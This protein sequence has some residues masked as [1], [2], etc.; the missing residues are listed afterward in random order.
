MLKSI[1]A[2][3]GLMSFALLA[4]SFAAD[5]VTLA[6]PGSVTASDAWIRWLPGELPA[7]AYVTLRNDSA[8]DT[9]LV[10]VSSPDY[11]T[12]MFHASRI[13]N[14][15]Q[16]ML[17]L[18]RVAIASHA[19]VSFTPQAMHVMLMLPTRSIIPGEEVTLIFR[20]SDGARLP[21]RF[22]VRRPDGT[23]MQA[24]APLRP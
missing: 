4:A 13:A 12:A 2:A 15:V 18:D 20:F 16:Q 10:G 19:E 21:V 5:V 9:T 6:A 1:L 7:A 22:E 14:G 17:P 23:S 3:S 8:H 11:G 24:P